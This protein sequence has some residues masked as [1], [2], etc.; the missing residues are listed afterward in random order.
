L[1]RHVLETGSFEHKKKTY[2]NL[3]TIHEVN[4]AVVI[5]MVENNPHISTRQISTETGI[6]QFSVGKILK[7]REYHPFHVELHQELHGDDFENRLTF[8][9]W[10]E[11]QIAEN[12]NL[13]KNV[14]F[15]DEC[16]FNND[17][18]VNK[19][20][21]HYWAVENPQWMRQRQTQNYWSLN[22]WGGFFYGHL[23]G[24]I[25]AEFLE[26]NLEDLLEDIL[27]ARRRGMCSVIMLGIWCFLLLL[28]FNS[29]MVP[30]RW[31]SASL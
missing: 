21:M 13:F 30:T 23:N 2:V 22:V 31:G 15:T 3:P 17:G 20:N 1:I 25:Y 7:N 10:A 19:H 16:N 28:C 27:L 24:V 4:E 8:C 18:H 9:R 29:N 12:E 26:Q 11:G 5:N 14:M 6:S